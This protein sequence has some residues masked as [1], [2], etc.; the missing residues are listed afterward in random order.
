MLAKWQGLDMQS[1]YQDWADA[2]Q[3]CSLGAIDYAIGQ[4]KEAQHPP[5]QGEF[6]ALCRGYTPPVDESRLIDKAVPTVTKD[7]A[8][9]N[10]E[11]IKLILCGARIVNT[12]CQSGMK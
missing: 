8:Q 12:A 10:L 1:V 9:A 5:S 2:L 6:K 3:G 11:K 4:A 7:Q